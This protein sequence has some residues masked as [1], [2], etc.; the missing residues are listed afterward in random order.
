MAYKYLLWSE[1]YAISSFADVPSSA[2]H[3]LAFH[4]QTYKFPLGNGSLFFKNQPGYQSFSWKA[5][6]QSFIRVVIE[7]R[8]STN[9]IV[10][11][12]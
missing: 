10:K 12:S 7:K 11:V 1:H 8:T 4:S 9:R 3:A 6:P 5:S 2:W